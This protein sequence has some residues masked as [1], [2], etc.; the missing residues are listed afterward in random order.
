[1]H[2]AA[3][4]LI[5]DAANTVGAVPDGW[6]RDRRGATERLR[7][8]LE[9][10]ARGSAQNPMSDADLEAKLRTA[11]AGWN[12]QHDVTPLIDAIWALDSNADVSKLASLAVPRE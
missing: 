1:M 8:A 7:D 3:P 6:W 5:V 11:A 9:T 10:A 4:L 12:V 2:D